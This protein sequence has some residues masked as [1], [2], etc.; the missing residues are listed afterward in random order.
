MKIAGLLAALLFA[1]PATAHGYPICDS[2]PRI[3]CVVDGDTVWFE[4]VKYRFADIDTP[5]KGALAECM[6]EGL[7]AFEATKRLAISVRRT[8]SRSR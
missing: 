8:S 3:T 2:S 4:G 7:W 6:Q 1:S 5:E